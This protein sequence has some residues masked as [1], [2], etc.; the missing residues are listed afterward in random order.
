MIPI[1]ARLRHRMLKEK[2]E[3][4]AY[5]YH[6]T[7]TSL[8]PDSDY[9]LLVEQMTKL[10]VDYPEFGSGVEPLGA[11]IA[12]KSASSEH[13]YPFLSLKKFKEIAKLVSF[14]GS[15]ADLVVQPKLDGIAV[16][17]IYEETPEGFMLL[18]R[19]VTR[20]DGSKGESIPEPHKLCKN[21]PLTFSK[22]LGLSEVRGEIVVSADDFEDANYVRELNGVAAFAN[23]RNYVAGSVFLGDLKERS[24]RKLQFIAWEAPELEQCLE[25]RVEALTQADFDVAPIVYLYGSAELTIDDLKGVYFMQPSFPFAI[26]GAVFKRLDNPHNHKDTNTHPTWAAALKL[27]SSE[28]TTTLLDVVWTT[29][30]TGAV[31]PVAVLMPVSVDGSVIS[32]A[33]L[34]NIDYIQ[35]LDLH[36]NQ[37]VVVTKAN[38]V[39]PRVL[40]AASPP[41]AENPVKEPVVCS[42]CGSKLIRTDA[43][44]TIFCRNYNCPAQL[45]TR[46]ERWVSRSAMDIDGVGPAVITKLINSG[47]KNVAG[48]YYVNPS[49]WT[50]LFGSTLGPKLQ[51]SVEDSKLR[52]LS[53][54]IYGL[55]IPG[56]GEVQA[57]VIAEKSGTLL[58]FAL[59]S[60]QQVASLDLTQKQ[61]KSLHDWLLTGA[62]VGVMGALCNQNVGVETSGTFSN[63]LSAMTAVFTGTL[64]EPREFYVEQL[65]N[66]GAKVTGSVSRK[67]THLILGE[68]PGSKY[69]KAKEL[70]VRILSEEELIQILVSAP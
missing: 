54:V 50:N 17:L 21:I 58:Q 56:I 65:R 33:T 31:T 18:N 27:E 64:S 15:G 2:V 9:D 66:R 32:K 35:S 12:T 25:L 57:R 55:A 30:A 20:G 69:D 43:G 29:G 11:P 46:L 41:R 10:E 52:P 67:T 36:L 1:E 24:A 13:K 34:H 22:D 8:M 19:A 38:D 45:Q 44:K 70:G 60:L 51:K 40:R 7:S 23:R 5:A 28:A 16:S 47:V 4:A 48:L 61:K 42:S 62:N 59:M 26:D 68:E 49:V 14:L 3:R 39:I 63:T 6:S 37:Q 53:A